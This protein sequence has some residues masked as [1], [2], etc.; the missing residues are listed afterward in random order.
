VSWQ[1]DEGEE[2]RFVEQVSRMF[3]RSGIAPVTG[4]I[5]GRLLVCDPPHQSSHELADT[6]HVSAGAV[7]V[8]T[9]MLEQIGIVERVR[10]PRDRAV[11]YRIRPDAWDAV[12]KREIEESR[13][14]RLLADRG[15]EVLQDAPDHV[16]A[17]M[18]SFRDLYAL[19]EEEMPRIQ[20]RWKERES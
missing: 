13:T 19:L 20:Q 7:S 3:E 15:L 9:R 17:R 18:Q 4:R 16:R 5:L 11:Y 10:F 12:W 2:R 1:M 8:A 6:L 14:M